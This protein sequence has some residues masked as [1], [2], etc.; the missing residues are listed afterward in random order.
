MSTDYRALIEGHLS[1]AS[2]LSKR[3]VHPRLLKLFEVGGMNTAFSH[4]KDV[5]LY[6]SEGRRYLDFL[7]GG[8]VYFIGR[9]HP[10]VNNAIEAVVDMDLPNLCVVNASVLGGVVAE[11]LLELAGPHLTKV[12]YANSGTE[13]TDVCVRFARVATGRR[14][15]LYLEGAFHGRSFAAISM[16]GFEEMRERQEPLMPTCTPIPPND[17]A[18]LRRELRRGDVAGFIYEGVQG[19]TLTALDPGYLREARTLCDEYGTLMIADEVQ[20]GFGR[21]GHWFDFHRTGIRPDMVTVSK[22][23]SGGAAPVSAVLY[24]EELYE[25]IYSNF[26]SG[27]IYFSTFAENNIS[28]AASLAT[29]SV[30][31]EID[32]PKRSMEIAKRL[33]DG[34]ARLAEHYD[35]IERVGGLGL[36]VGIYFRESSS[37]ALRVQQELLNLADRGSFA[38]AVNVEMYTRQRVIMQIP[39]PGVNAVK[40]LPPVVSTDAD[41]DYFLAAFEDA[42]ASL[43]SIQRGPASTLSRGFIEQTTKAVRN[44]MPG[45][46]ARVEKGE[47]EKSKESGHPD[48]FA[49]PKGGPPSTRLFAKPASGVYAEDPVADTQDLSSQDSEA[50]IEEM[51]AKQTQAGDE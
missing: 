17:I 32:A 11:Q 22:T 36:M 38:A 43:Y 31:K 51:V 4:A 48:A 45:A 42:L 37:A 50:V 8:G 33:R 35:V 28:M 10:E 7:A 40:I 27:P 44:L 14:R 12:T 49:R 47:S 15:Y 24:T 5:Y 19:M 39:G 20:T 23:L 16:C 6:D 18:A 26:T 13:A 3:H 21:T 30:L 2:H 9:N 29:L 41:I 46:A 1:S 25:K 34:L